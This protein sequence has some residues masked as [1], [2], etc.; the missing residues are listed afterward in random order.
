M[1]SDCTIEVVDTG[2]VY[3]NAMPHLRSRHAYFPTAVQLD[4]GDIVVGM[5][6][7]SAFEALDVRS[8][9]AIS[10][11]QGQTWSEPRQLFEPD[12][13]TC[14]VSS[15]CRIGRKP[16]G[17]LIGWAG[18]FQRKC[19]DLGLVNPETDGFCE[20][21]YATIESEDGGRTWSSLRMIQPPEDF[22][23]FEVCAP[24]FAVGDQRLLVVTHPFLAWNGATSPWGRQGLALASDDCGSSWSEA[25]TTF[26]DSSGEH[27]YFE[28]A[29]TTLSDG[30]VMAMCW[31]TLLG[32]GATQA[33]RM[34]LSDDGGRSFSPSLATPLRG[35]TC[36]PLGLDDGHVL[37]TYRR[38]DKKGLWAQVADLSSDEWR[39]VDEQLL[40][41][42]N[43]TSHDADAPGTVGAL[44]TLRFGCPAVIRLQCGEIFVVF[45][46]IEDCCSV[47]RWIR[48]NCK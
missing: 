32:S 24:P 47:I 22:R 7:G 11:D 39:P 10:S 31:D 16:D 46:G 20:T 19:P 18:L 2:I 5:D 27:A 25:V 48:L 34:A 4:G 33:N 21:R 43:V 23:Q 41:G 15:S 6:I 9:V 17:T 14:P 28:S 42:G 8:F 26:A 3:R 29:L 30:R 44:S 40:W 37:V 45:W 13:T 1:Q 35:E 38:V 36:R 12:Q